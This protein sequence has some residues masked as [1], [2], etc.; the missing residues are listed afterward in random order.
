MATI[1]T[2]KTYVLTN[3]FTGSSKPLSLS[4]DQTHISI[5]DTVAADIHTQ[6]W[7]VTTTDRLPYYRLHIVSL[8]DA[9][10]LDV[11]NDNDINSINVYM[12]STG[13]YSGQYWRFDNW[14][15]SSVGGGYRLS[16]SFTGLNMHLDVNSGS[17]QAFLGTGDTSG[18]HWM[19]DTPAASTSTSTSLTSTATSSTAPTTATSGSATNTSAPSSNGSGSNSLSPGVIAGIAV[20]G[21]AGIALIA[22][23]IMF[24]LR[25]KKKQTGAE[26]SVHIHG[27]LKGPP[28][29]YAQKG[30]NNGD[31]HISELDAGGLEAG[32]TQPLLAELPS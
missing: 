20:G 32:R 19:L 11:I 5:P 26:P 6:E 15:S 13:Q 28:P 17:L 27:D 4:F 2:S 14:T 30:W 3:L 7:F 1:D 23:I 24:L 16:N 22:V 21:V 10:S 12:T 9:L 18:Q 25:R 29:T 31:N 8:G